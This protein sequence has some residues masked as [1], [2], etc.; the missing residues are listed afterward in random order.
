MAACTH[1]HGTRGTRHVSLGTAGQREGPRG[2]TAGRQCMGFAGWC[3]KHRSVSQQGE[4]LFAID[5]RIASLG[6]TCTTA[7]ACSRMGPSMDR[8]LV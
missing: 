8:F 7:A 4:A 1:V 6:R 5:A 3:C 2:R